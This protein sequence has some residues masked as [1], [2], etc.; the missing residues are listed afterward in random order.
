M[1]FV[2][3]MPKRC[4][5]SRH[6][7]AP[8]RKNSEYIPSPPLFDGGGCADNGSE[9]IPAGFIIT[10]PN[11]TSQDLLFVQLAETLC[12]DGSAR[13]VRLRSGE[14]PNL[15]AALR[16]IIRDASVAKGSSSDDAEDDGEVD[17]EESIGQDASTP[18][19]S[20]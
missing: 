9:K 7:Y 6:S 3:Q 18:K 17:G 10:G 12:G 4:A 15:K 1:S 11:I 20:P 19:T 14:V 16:R 5:R 8:P 2:E 13:F